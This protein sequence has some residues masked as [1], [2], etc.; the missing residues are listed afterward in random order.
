MKT[1]SFAFILLVATGCISGTVISFAQTRVPGVTAGMEFT[2]SQ[3]SL[4]LSSD[5]SLQQPAGL[6]DVNMTDYYKVTVTEVSGSNVS[7]HIRWHFTNSTDIE[8]DGSVSVETTA[9][10]GG[11]WLIVGSELNATDRVHPNSA[12]DFSTINETVAWNYGAYQRSAN[13]LSLVFANE[14]SD[15]PD[16]NYVE[17]VDTYFD[18]QTGALVQLEDTHTNSN[19]LTTLKVTWRLIS[20][21]AWASSDIQQDMSLQVIISAAAVVIIVSLLVALLYRKR[22]LARKK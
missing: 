17:N 8:K 19:P 15:F 12:Q 6:V 9:Y 21:N 10:Q 11:F 20:Q 5:A 7:T 3:S 16:S 1:R 2:Y 18:R 14:K 22:L 4:W 13:H